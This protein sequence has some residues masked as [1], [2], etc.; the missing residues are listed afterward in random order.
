MRAS[1]AHQLPQPACIDHI[2]LHNRFYD[3]PNHLS[4]LLDTAL[5]NEIAPSLGAVTTPDLIPYKTEDASDLFLK[6]LAFV[7]LR[8]K[9]RP[10][11]RLQRWESQI[12]CNIG[13]G[14]AGVRS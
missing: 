9:V 12:E 3:I 5:A 10:L 11:G 14:K 7:A 8:A 13:Y 1:F 6:I 4:D 2:S